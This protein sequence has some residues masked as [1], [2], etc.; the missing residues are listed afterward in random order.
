VKKHT[1]DYLLK[2]ILSLENLNFHKF[3]LQTNHTVE[4]DLYFSNSRIK[5]LN[6]MSEDMIKENKKELHT[7]VRY[8][9]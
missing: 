3:E 9:I 6:K 5:K 1:Q 2:E 8:I 7:V 4:T